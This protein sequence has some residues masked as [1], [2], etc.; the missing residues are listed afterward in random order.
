MISAASSASS[1]SRSAMSRTL[2]SSSVSELQSDSSHP[3][4]GAGAADAAV[5]VLG[6][7]LVSV[8]RWENQAIL[9][10]YVCEGTRGVR[11][12]SGGGS[13]PGYALIRC[14]GVMAVRDMLRW[15]GVG[16]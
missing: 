2:T 15:V 5:L 8:R 10:V 3:G 11:V 14:G 9:E 16:V 12:G 6:V 7:G 1:A 4:A 13:N